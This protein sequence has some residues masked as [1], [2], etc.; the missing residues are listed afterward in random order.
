MGVPEIRRQ[1]ARAG[2]QQVGV[3]EH[4]V[5]EVVLRVQPQRARLD[6]HVDVFGHQD[7]RALGKAL[8]EEGHHRQDV[9]VAAPGGQARRQVQVDCL[10]LQKQFAGGLA[11]GG[12]RESDA[13][14]DAVGAGADDLVEHAAGLTRVARH[15]RHALL[16]SIELLEGHDRHEQIV[17]FE[18]V[19]AGGVVHQHVGVEN[20][21]LDFGGLRRTFGDHAGS[22]R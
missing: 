19:D 22:G 2:V 17:L 7:D 4:L 16:V 5:V 14:V 11:A 6:A 15:F 1:F 20:E 9:V 21:Q 12:L 13:V 10:G 3:F 18:A 8:G